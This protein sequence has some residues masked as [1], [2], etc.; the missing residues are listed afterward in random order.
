MD[1]HSE[2]ES[3]IVIDHDATASV[4]MNMDYVA[5]AAIE[6]D[7][8]AAMDITTDSVSIEAIDAGLGA[9]LEHPDTPRTESSPSV[10]ATSDIVNINSKEHLKPVVGMIFDNLT[11][12]EEFYKAYAHNAG[13]SVRVGQQK[14]GNEKVLFKRYYC[15]REGFTKEKVPD[16]SD[17]S[18]KK[19]KAPKLME[20]RCGCPAHIVVKLHNDKKYRIASMVEE[21]SHGF[22]SPDKRHLLRSNRKV[23]ERAKSTLFNCH[24]ASIGTSQ[25][26]RLLHVSEGGCKNVGCTKR[27][28]QNYYRDLRNKIKDA[29]AQ[30]FVAQLE[31][32]KEVNPAFFYE[33]EVNEEGRLVRVFWADALSRKNYSVFGDVISVDATYTTNQYNMKFVPFTGINHHLQSVFLGAAFL[34]NEKIESYVWL[35]KTFLKA[36]GGVAPFLRLM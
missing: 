20:T 2:F 11:D 18:V 6:T 26:Y 22:V 31:R 23:S 35:F 12:V 10:A 5:G 21:H 4:G 28:L 24:K 17:E 34:A 16:A 25:A 19:R 14:K 13:F 9:Y 32:K 1:R 33:F 27:D 36:M 7:D 3:A 29:D 8:V 30:M 15:S